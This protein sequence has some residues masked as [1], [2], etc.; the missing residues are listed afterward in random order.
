MKGDGWSFDCHAILALPPHLIPASKDR[1][2]V[3]LPSEVTEDQVLHYLTY[4]YSGR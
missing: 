2:V 3:F 1:L 4:V